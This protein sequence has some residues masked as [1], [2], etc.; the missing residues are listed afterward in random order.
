MYLPKNEDRFIGTFDVTSVQPLYNTPLH[1]IDLD[2]TWTCFDS[3][4]FLPGNFT[5]EF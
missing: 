2:M 4:I 1:H 5:K 3:Q